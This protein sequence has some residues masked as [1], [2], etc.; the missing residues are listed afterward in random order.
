VLRFIITDFISQVK[1]WYFGKLE[2]TW[3]NGI[4]DYVC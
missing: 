2:S 1:H 3:F 4:C